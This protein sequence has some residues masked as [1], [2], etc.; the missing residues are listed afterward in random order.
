MPKVRNRFSG[1]P[2]VGRSVGLIVKRAFP[3]RRP[4]IAPLRIDRHEVS[5]V[6]P[7]VSRCPE[8]CPQMTQTDADVGGG[9]GEHHLQACPEKQR[10]LAVAT[11]RSA[12]NQRLVICV[13]LRD[14][15]AKQTQPDVL[16]KRD[17]D[18]NRTVTFLRF[19]QESSLETIAATRLKTRQIQ[20]IRE[21]D[22]DFYAAA[23]ICW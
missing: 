15:R 2:A 13:N 1:L 5:P 19:L 18:V 6:R 14:L 23:E 4:L 16:A 20:A 8:C 12:E 10:A 7:A 22:M 17:C 11:S 9:G 21:E 3:A